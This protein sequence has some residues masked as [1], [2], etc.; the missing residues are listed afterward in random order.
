MKTTLTTA[1]I[2]ALMLSACGPEA[3]PADIRNVIDND[4]A[5]TTDQN[6]QAVTLYDGI[7]EQIKTETDPAQLEALKTRLEQVRIEGGL[8]EK[9]RPDFVDPKASID[10]Q[11]KLKLTP[12]E[13]AHRIAVNELLD[14][15]VV[16][17]E[18]WKK[19]VADKADPAEIQ[20]LLE[21]SN[22]ANQKMMDEQLGK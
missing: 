21:E 5:P 9:G 17:E 11:V 22:A 16:A 7:A 15:A 14:Q 2:L 13:Q 8:N 18:A 4:P 1:L 19:A 20:R 10:D 6:V 12:E 3:T